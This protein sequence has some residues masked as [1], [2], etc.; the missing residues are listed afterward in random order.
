M[1]IMKE[2]ARQ[3][4]FF[5]I[6][7]LYFMINFYIGILPGNIDN[8]IADLSGA[9]QS[10]IGLVIVFRLTFGTISL[11]AFGYF[12]EALATRFGKKKLF[13]LTN[14]IS[15]CFNGMIILSQDYLY[16]L[17]I[18]IIASIANG[19]FLPIGFSIVSDLYTP[20]DRGKRFGMLQFSLV[21]GNG[22]GVALGGML[23][24]RVGFSISFIIGILCLIYYFFSGNKPPNK[25]LLAKSEDSSSGREYNY[26]ITLSNVLKLLK[27]KT[28]AGILISVFTYGIAISTLANWG[29]YY[30]TS[31]L[32]NETEA[33]LIFTISGL[34]ALGGTILGGKLGDIY[35]NS[36]MPKARVII[37]FGGLVLGIILLLIF[38][39]EPVLLLSFF[40]FFFFSFANGNQFAIYSEVSAPELRGTVN[41]LSGIMINIGG[42]T[43][44]V[45]ISTLIQNNLLSLSITLVLVIWLIGSFS[46]II[47]YF[48]YLKDA[49]HR[50]LTTLRR[51]EDLMT[52]K[53]N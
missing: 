48:Y 24:W 35:Y 30:L 4:T 51:R 3:K 17:T 29:V 10:G 13:I 23:G 5:L 50:K 20:K 44:N 2:Q 40:G 49:E 16:F 25:N 12:G 31:K 22:V 1:I 52:I 6:S 45:I 38:Y 9:T 39:V 33:I 32:G 47:P 8:L 14:L 7:G 43:G 26:K 46:W 21:L 36:N 11:V 15:I 37:S 42:I 53:S 19:A 41:A 34:G 18:T 28:I 27:T